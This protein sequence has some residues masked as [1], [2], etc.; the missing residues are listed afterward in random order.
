MNLAVKDLREKD[1][2]SVIDY[3]LQADESTLKNM[4]ADINLLPNRGDWLQVMKDALKL[5]DIKKDRYYQLWLADNKPIGHSNINRIVYGDHAFMHLHMWHEQNR[6]NGYGFNL[7]KFSIPNYF[8]RFKLEKLI[9]EPYALNPA[10]KKTL[11]KLGFRFIKSYDTTPGNI[12]FHQT[13]ARY[14]LKRNERY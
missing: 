5:P 1:I 14:E 4:G 7:L 10:P 6:N 13:V 8:N 9:C 12:A 3:F 11:A 2:S